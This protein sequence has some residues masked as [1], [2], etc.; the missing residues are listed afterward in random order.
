L[1]SGIVFPSGVGVGLEQGQAPKLR[2]P[3]VN[4]RIRELTGPEM[5][6]QCRM[7]VTENTSFKARSTITKNQRAR[8]SKK[9]VWLSL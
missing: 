1:I 9:P 3:S 7:A 2:E 6:K 5:D 4:N 8:N